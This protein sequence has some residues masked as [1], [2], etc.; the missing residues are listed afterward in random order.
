[1]NDIYDLHPTVSMSIAAA[2]RILPGERAGEGDVDPRWQVILD[3]DRFITTDPDPIWE[4]ILRWGVHEDEDLRTAIGVGLLEDLLRHHFSSFI[5]R[6]EIAVRGHERFADA[7]LRCRATGDALL[8]S[9]FE[10][11]EG[12]RQECLARVGRERPDTDPA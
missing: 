11:F 1:M 7:F 12:V 8:P 3:I 10:R 2:E 5:D 6:V 9:H 4:F